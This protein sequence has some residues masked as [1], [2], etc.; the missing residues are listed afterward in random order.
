MAATIWLWASAGLASS[1]LRS[2]RYRRVT[3]L[4]NLP[5][6]SGVRVVQQERRLDAV[7]G[8]GARDV[9]ENQAGHARLKVRAGDPAGLRGLPGDGSGLGV[10]GPLHD[11]AQVA[12]GAAAGGVGGGVGAPVRLAE[13]DAV[14]DAGDLAPAVSR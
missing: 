6:G 7:G 11:D 8:D 14:L 12:G 5:R 9:G 2:A 4:P 1:S 3:V 10:G 13:V